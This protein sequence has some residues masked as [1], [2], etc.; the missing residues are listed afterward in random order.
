MLITQGIASGRRVFEVMDEPITLGDAPDAYPLP[1]IKKEICFE[2]VNFAYGEGQ[3]LV[4][5]NVTMEAHPNDV[6]AIVGKTGSGKSSLVNLIPRF[7]EIT[8]G[9]IRIDGHD[10]GAVT[11]NSLRNQIGIVMQESLLFSASI[12]ENIAFGRPEA[13]EESIIAAAKAADAHGFIMETP[14][15][16]D[17]LVGERGV[18]LSGGQRQ[19]VAIAR[20]LLMD[21]SILILDDS[22]S[23]VDTHT[24]HDIQ[25]ALLGLMAGRIT[26]I[27]AQ[28]LTSGMH[29]S[30]ILVLDGGQI[31]EQGTHDDL[32]AQKG[33]YKEIY[34]LQLADQE[35]VR[36]ETLTFD[37]AD[38]RLAD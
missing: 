7:Y 13:N 5:K 24:E 25:A 30:Q 10:I 35:R 32:L 18:T 17:T 26:F 8:G 38:I 36:R 22:T 37:E 31:V 11:L 21:P 28:R 27:V 20:A 34:D 12:R 2:N 1:P 19:R 6:I 4:L 14:D 16:Y 33:V 3:P 15:G 29:A 9:R 23:S